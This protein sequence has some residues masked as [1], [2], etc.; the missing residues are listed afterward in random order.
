LI[1]KFWQ[2][3]QEFFQIFI[4]GIIKNF[5]CFIKILIAERVK[6]HIT[7]GELKLIVFFVEVL[8]FGDFYS[9]LQCKYN[10]IWGCAMLKQ[11]RYKSK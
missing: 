8:G 10:N 5:F 4:S 2:V 7:G 9:T 11:T 1:F 3:S 6:I